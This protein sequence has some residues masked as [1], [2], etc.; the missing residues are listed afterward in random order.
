MSEW[1]QSCTQS[2]L[3][4]WSAGGCQERLWGTGI[5]LLQDFC[6]K[7][8]QA[9]VGQP[10]KVLFLEFS[11]V[12]PGAHPLTKKPEDSAKEIGDCGLDLKN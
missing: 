5:L 11:S 10:I 3:A 8:M 9:V 4:F 2:S 6:S 1:I 7:T 12:S